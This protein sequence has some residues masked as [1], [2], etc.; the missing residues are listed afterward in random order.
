MDSRVLQIL[1]V[2]PARDPIDFLCG[3]TPVASTTES[4]WPGWK[5][6]AGLRLHTEGSQ[7]PLRAGPLGGPHI[8]RGRSV[9]SELS[10]S[11]ALACVSDWHQVLSEGKVA[12]MRRGWE[13]GGSLGLAKGC[14]RVEWVPEIKGAQS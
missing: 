13:Q 3:P 2:F 9:G 4:G 11:V 8:E 14:W 6:G 5:T 12:G 7:V 10:S 1:S